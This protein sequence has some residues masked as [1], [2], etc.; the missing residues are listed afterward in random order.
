MLINE[1]LTEKLEVWD[2]RT[3]IL[4][5]DRFFTII[6]EDYLYF[7]GVSINGIIDEL[8]YTVNDVSNDLLGTEILCKFLSEFLNHLI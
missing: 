6:L 7:M 1:Y 4:D 3:I 2:S 8:L 5:K